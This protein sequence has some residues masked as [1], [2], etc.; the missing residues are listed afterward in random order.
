MELL[1][2]AAVIGI[3]VAMAIPRGRHLLD[4]ASV[5]G[6]AGDA[7]AILELAR[8]TAMTRGQRVSV[9]MDTGPARLTMRAGSDTLAARNEKVLH[10]VRF[11]TTRSTVVYSQLGLGYGVSNLTLVVTRG[12]AAE[13]V[14]VS[15]LGRVRR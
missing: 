12:S 2:V 3:L 10:G 13:T 6:A 9:D 4:A 15:R 7:A 1:L 5:R 8:H 11:S 14:T